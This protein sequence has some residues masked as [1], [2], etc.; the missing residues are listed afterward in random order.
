MKLF[1]IG[2]SNHSIEFFLSLLQ[3]H[4]ISAVADV[5]S[6]PYSRYSPHFNQKNLKKYLQE[7]NIYYVFLGKELGA[8]TKNLSCY[9]NGK[10]L[11]ELIANTEEFKQGLARIYQGLE[12]YNIA[13]MCAEQDPITCHR[14]ILVSRHLKNKGLNIYHILKNGELEEHSN[15][16]ERLLKINNL[17]E[18][19]QLS[20][21]LSLFDDRNFNQ[22]VLEVT[23]KT[24]DT[25]LEEAYKIQGDK[26]AYVSKQ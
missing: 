2:H 22:N 13:L 20:L 3:K 8:R 24:Q 26:I 4:E 10:A 6:H 7:S 12:N 23:K 5:R 1:T 16:E 15:L 19:P 25:I 18:K 9:V 17:L 21:Q 11:Y 14:S